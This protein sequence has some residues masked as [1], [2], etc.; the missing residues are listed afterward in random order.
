MKYCVYADGSTV[1]QANDTICSNFNNA[2]SV[3]VDEF[4]IPDT[5]VEVHSNM[6]LVDL[7]IVALFFLPKLLG[8]RK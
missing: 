4:Q 5:S 2:N 1:Q 8:K 3:I 6:G 7:A